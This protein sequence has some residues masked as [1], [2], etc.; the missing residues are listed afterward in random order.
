MEIRVQGLEIIIGEATIG[1]TME[2]AKKLYD[3]LGKIF[4]KEEPE[5]KDVFRYIPPE[6]SP[7]W[8]PPYI[9]T[10]SGQWIPCDVKITIT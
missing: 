1:L 9:W 7:Y 3:E 5:K 6:R 8:Y 2:Q 10:S 4:D